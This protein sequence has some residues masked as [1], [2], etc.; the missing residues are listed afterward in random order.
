MRL[1]VPDDDHID[2]SFDINLI[3]VQFIHIHFH[4][5][6]KNPKLDQILNVTTTTDGTPSPGS[7]LEKSLEHFIWLTS[8]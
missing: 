4:P 8:L 2:F 7:E 3:F 1:C 5:K 6:L